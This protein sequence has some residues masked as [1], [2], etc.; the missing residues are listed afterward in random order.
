[1]VEQGVMKGVA[2]Y[3]IQTDRLNIDKH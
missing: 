1:M 3:A 2:C